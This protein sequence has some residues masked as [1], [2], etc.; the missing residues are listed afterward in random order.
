MARLLGVAEFIIR[1]FLSIAMA[2]LVVMMMTIVSDVFMRFAFNA[3]ITG[4]YDVVEFSLIVAVFYSLGAV[5]TGL[6][7][8]LID[9]ID[10]LVRP[11]TVLLLQRVSALLSAAILV[12]IFLSMLTPAMQSYQ[13]GEM[14][15]E[16]N[17]PTWIMWV[18]ALVGMAGGVLA[19]I[20]KL[21][22]PTPV[23]SSDD[24]Q[25]DVAT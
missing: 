12:F 9:L 17:M 21:L 11:R 13:Y 24:I 14:R 7:E 8:I 2:A 18:V 15:L 5:I 3:P 10:H 23:T 6:H 22:K 25:Q 16:L 20:V 1:M 4:S 19:S